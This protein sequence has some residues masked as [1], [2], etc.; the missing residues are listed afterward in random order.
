MRRLGW[1]ISKGNAE[2]ATSRRRRS[3]VLRRTAMGS[4]ERV[5]SVPFS[6]DQVEAPR[7]R[8]VARPSG[9][10]RESRAT[11]AVSSALEATK[12]WTVGWP[13]RVNDEVNG[14]DV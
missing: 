8:K 2:L 5:S 11:N 1:R 12:R 3:P 4:K 10:T 13:A 14:D 6:G 9:V 7:Q